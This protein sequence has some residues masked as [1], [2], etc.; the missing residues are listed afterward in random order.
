MAQMQLSLQPRLRAIAD[1]VPRGSRLADVGTDHAYLP[2][3]LLQRGWIPWAVATD[4]HPEPLERGRRT[5]KAFGM[6][7][8]IS[9]RLCDGLEA[10]SAEE[11]DAVVIAGMGGE[12]IA[13]ILD[14]VPWSR[15]KEVLV[16][17]MSRPEF[18]RP[19]L[20]GHGW[21]ILGETLVEDKGYIYPILQV[22]GGEMPPLAPGEAYYGLSPT[23]GPLFRE[24]LRIW[25]QRLQRAVEGLRR[26]EEP[27]GRLEELERDL[28]ALA[29]KEETL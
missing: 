13:A 15:E 1:L 6:E 26:A 21:R 27:G 23:S 20:A 29:E 24:Y 10:V 12:T 17:P 16:Q 28:A 22:S 19:W 14:A 18:L 2:I 4:I 8:R 3:C 25:R 11:I 5:A 7:E 9:F